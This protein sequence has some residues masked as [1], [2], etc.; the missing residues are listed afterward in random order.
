MKPYF[1]GITVYL[2]MRALSYVVD[3]RPYPLWIVAVDA[4]M[5]ALLM[6]IEKIVAWRRRG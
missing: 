1:I 3:P 4:G 2:V 6:L 5:I